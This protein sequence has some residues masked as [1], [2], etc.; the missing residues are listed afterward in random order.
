MGIHPKEIKLVLVY[1]VG[2]A[3]SIHLRCI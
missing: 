2:V 1:V 3:R